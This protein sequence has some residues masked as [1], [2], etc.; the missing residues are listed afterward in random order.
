MSLLFSDNKKLFASYGIRT[1]FIV[2]TNPSQSID[3]LSREILRCLRENDYGNTYE[4]GSKNAEFVMFQPLAEVEREQAIEA[5]T[6]VVR[7]L[8]MKGYTVELQSCGSF[9]V[10]PQTDRM[11][12]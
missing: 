6:M 3:A 9:H 8:D 11:E 5:F 7:L 12:H 2:F 4:E 10:L 1:T